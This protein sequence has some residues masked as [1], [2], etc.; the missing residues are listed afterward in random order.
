M[1]WFL[2]LTILG[3]SGG[4]ENVIEAEPDETVSVDV[5]LFS[6]ERVMSEG[7]RDT[8]SLDG[9]EVYPQPAQGVLFVGFA[10]SFGEEVRLELFDVLGRRA[11]VEMLN[12]P[13]TAIDVSGMTRGVYFLSART[14]TNQG[15]MRKVVIF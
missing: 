3:V 4:F 12:G 1:Y 10:Y 5:V 11:Y 6:G 14:D 2:L 13:R 8:L 15:V 9:L 7:K